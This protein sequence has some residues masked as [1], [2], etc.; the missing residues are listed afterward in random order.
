MAVSPALRALLDRIIDYAG[1]Y[2]PTSLSLG[3]SIANYREY[4]TGPYSWM[5]RWLVL[6]SEDL[7]L[8]PKELDGTF[9]VLGETIVARAAVMESKSVLGVPAYCEVPLSELDN[10]RTA[11]GFAKI[12]TGSIKPEGIPTVEAVAA[13]ILK[14]AQLKL[15]FKAT[16]GLHHPV[17]AVY[18]LTYDADAPRAVMHGFLNLF[19]AAAFA[20]HGDKSILPIL[21]ETDAKAFR[22]DDSAH[23]RE[24]SLSVAQIRDA[25]TNFAHSFGSCSFT[26]PVEDLKSLGFL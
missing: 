1:L 20:W 24:K 22:F 13:F 5:L 19:L 23:W 18:P 6:G 14:C 17:R 9:A 10:V 21:S 12:R 3:A 11:G 8:A 16:A 4:R 2:P 15:P 25:R 7:P 26:E